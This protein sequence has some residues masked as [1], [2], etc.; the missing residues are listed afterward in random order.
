MGKDFV[1]K[2]KKYDIEYDINDARI[3]DDA[4]TWINKIKDSFENGIGDYSLQQKAD[5]S[6][7]HV[8]GGL[9]VGDNSVALGL[10]DTYDLDIEEVDGATLVINETANPNWQNM[11][12]KS[13]DEYK[14]IVSVSGDTITLDSA[15]SSTPTTISIITQVA[16]G[17]YSF[18]AGEYCQAFGEASHAEGLA[19][20]AVGAGSFSGGY[21]TLANTSYC[22]AYGDHVIATS[23]SQT[24][25]GKYNV[26][27]FNDLFIV[28]NGSASERSD[29]FIVRADGRATIGANPTEDLD[30]ATKDYVDKKVALKGH[31]IRVKGFQVDGV[32]TVDMTFIVKSKRQ[33]AY[34]QADLY[35]FF[36]QGQTLQNDTYVQTLGN[37]NNNISYYLGVR[38]GDFRLYEHDLPNKV[39]NRSIITS[40][41]DTAFD[42]TNE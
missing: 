35:A 11:V 5:T 40:F 33:T 30:V 38:S 42:L 15:F 23:P 10:G 14:R 16:M 27:N 2:V 19:C 37:G 6:T 25:L 32:D 13:G 26:I 22:F 21:F 41:S 12:A 39:I 18:V 3:D 29:A 4:V 17:N 31:L 36:T 8:K 9:A 7:E 28:G 34:L 20:K 24:A 1:N